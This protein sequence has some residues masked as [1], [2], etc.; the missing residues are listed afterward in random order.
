MSEGNKTSKLSFLDNLKFV[1]KLKQV[2]HI[3][4]IVL[5]IFVLILLVILFGDFGLNN[6]TNSQT[7]DVSTYTSVYQ[8]AEKLETKLKNVLSKIKNVGTIEVMVTV[9]EP[10]EPAGQAP[11]ENGEVIPKVTG[12]VVVS[13][14]AE[15][16]AVKLNIITA[17]QTLVNIEQ[18][19]IQ[20]FVGN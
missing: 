7:T 10:Q 20:V 4:I 13:S 18:N 8:Y 17:V 9:E 12:V 5:V 19:K 15:S 16:T 2:K 1:K 3:G 11:N 14:G 6:K